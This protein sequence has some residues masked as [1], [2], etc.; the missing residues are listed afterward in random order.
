MVLLF[1][2]ANSRVPASELTRL[3]SIVNSQLAS[4]IAPTLFTTT[5]N[6]PNCALAASRQP[7]YSYIIAEHL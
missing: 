5:S 1:D 4:L 7:T 6:P 3:M 2:T